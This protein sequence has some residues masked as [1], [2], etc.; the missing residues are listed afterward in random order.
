MSSWK[1]MITASAD[2][3]QRT[4]VHSCQYHRSSQSCIGISR[5][6][7]IGHEILQSQ[8]QCFS[9]NSCEINNLKINS[10]KQLDYD[11]AEC[12]T[13][14]QTGIWIAEHDVFSCGSC[15]DCY[16]ASKHDIRMSQI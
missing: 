15:G 13:C 11:S 7:C 2:W 10:K 12:I 8:I 4:A 9:R 16:G 5:T 6:K 14:G 3:H 1:L